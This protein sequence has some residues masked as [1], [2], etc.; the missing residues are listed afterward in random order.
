M[1]RAVSWGMPR[2]V[3]V[4][5]LLLVVIVATVVVGNSGLAIAYYALVPIV[6]AAF[7]GGWREAVLAAVAASVLYPVSAVLFTN[8]PSGIDL[9]IAAGNR[10]AVYLGIALLVA[11]LRQRE[12]RATARVAA[13][14][15]QL[16]E[17][18]ALRAV[19][20]PEH[21]PPRPG[22][23][24]ATTFIPA[25]GPVAG[26]FYL[27]ADG[28]G[29]STT[30]VVGDVVGHGLDA[31]RRGAYVRAALSTF[32]TFTADPAQLL[33]LAHTALVS[34][35]GPSYDFITAVCLNITLDTPD[36]PEAAAVTGR[37]MPALDG[38]GPV[39]AELR[40]ACAGH[41][42][43][44]DL[45]TGTPLSGGPA[46]MPLGLDPAP[47]ALSSSTRALTVGAG[48]LAFTDGLTEARPA[49]R[50]TGTTLELFGAERAQ[51]ILRQAPTDPTEI[52]RLM[53]TAVAH[54]AAGPLADD[55]CLVA[56]RTTLTPTT[57][58]AA[59]STNTA[60]VT[61]DGPAVTTPI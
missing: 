49:H 59:T 60:S 50:G 35:C 20:T 24:I 1:S 55:L 48:I 43:R 15:S 10:A 58:I 34:H 4:A 40:W 33:Q 12:R 6:L 52:L 32:A 51:T 31:A 8:Q 27:V 23:D 22:L 47:L 13:Q 53:S 45:D 54:F 18:E 38:P 37:E 19:L 30:I 9:W 36:T 57:S 3:L 5:V 28:P 21:I 39:I 26:D 14:Q 46:S 7:W 16:D 25:E 61:L 17:L 41:D 42:L 2:A 11:V 44:W 56:C 29:D